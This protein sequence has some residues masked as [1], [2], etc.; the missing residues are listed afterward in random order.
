MT[1]ATNSF[2]Q[3]RGR[4]VLLAI[5][6][7]CAFWRDDTSVS[8]DV[9]TYRALMPS[10]ATLPGSMLI[11]ISSPYK[12]AGLLYDKW[13]APFGKDDDRVLVIQATSLQLNPTLDPA[14]VEQALADDPAAARAEWLGEFRPDI[15]GYVPL[16]LIESA[17]DWGVTVRPPRQGISYC[18][19]VD[20]ASGTGKDSFAVGIAHTDADAVIL[21]LCHEIKPPFNPQSAVDEVAAILQ[22]YGCFSCRGDKYSAGFVIEAFGR[23]GITYEYSEIDRSGLYISA[24]PLFTAGRARL[25]DN[26][27]LVAQFASLERRT[28]AGGRDQVDHGRNAHDDAANASAGALALAYSDD[29]DP[30]HWRALA[31]KELEYEASLVGRPQPPPTWGYPVH[32]GPHN[33]TGQHRRHLPNV[34][35]GN[36]RRPAKPL[37]PSSGIPP[38]CHIWRRVPRSR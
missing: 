14:I 31:R 12:K 21:D 19:F 29:A 16:E 4:T 10:L 15:G 5:L 35:P 20:A 1:I 34:R 23:N 25:I 6:D 7:E 36:R 2:R 38:R 11:G 13:K 22:S 18:G 26:P 9:E 30:G 17:V 24:L 37:D 8:P 3:V 33:K 28:S 27:K 32:E